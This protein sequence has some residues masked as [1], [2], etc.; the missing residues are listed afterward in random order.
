MFLFYVLYAATCERV[1]VVIGII[2]R[3]VALMAFWNWFTRGCGRECNA[4][5]LFESYTADEE[6]ASKPGE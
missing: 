6:S 1:W 2:M 4:I 5:R 3:M